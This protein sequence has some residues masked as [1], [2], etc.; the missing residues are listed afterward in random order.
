MKTMFDTA[1]T[2]SPLGVSPSAGAIPPGKSPVARHH[3]LADDLGC[4]QV[5]HQRHRAGVAERAIEGAAHLARHAKR[6]AVGLRNVDAFDFRALVE[7]VGWGEAQ[8]PLPGAVGGDLLGHDFGPRECAA[9]GEPVE[10]R[11]GDIAHRREL[12]RAAMVDPM[13]ELRGAHLEV[14][15]GHARFGEGA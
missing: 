2:P 3:D 8:E 15:L 11:T 1:R 12:A 4:G 7:A 9:F 14:A 5:A 13:P 6:A 10:H